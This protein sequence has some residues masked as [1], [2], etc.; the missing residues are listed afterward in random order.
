MYTVMHHAVGP[1]PL[2]IL[3]KAVAQQPVVVMVDAQEDMKQ[4]SSGIFQPTL[5]RNTSDVSA[6]NH[7]VLVVGYDATA[8]PGVPGTY[9][10]ASWA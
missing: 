1:W 3:W 2:A 9:W 6:L 10:K 7:A 4:Y 8:G 5:C